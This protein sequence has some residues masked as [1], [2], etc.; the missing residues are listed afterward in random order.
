MKSE[1]DFDKKE[2]RYENKFV[3]PCL[4]KKEV[5]AVIFSNSHLFSE[6]YYERQINNIYFDSLDMEGFFDNVLGNSDRIKIRIR[7]YGDFEKVVNPVLELK[8]KRG[9][10]GTKLSFPLKNFSFPLSLDDM[11]EVFL[12]SNLPE[13]L[14]D[15]LKTQRF[16]LLNYYTRKYFLS[17]CK[18]FRITIDS[19]LTYGGVLTQN[20]LELS[21]KIKEEYNILELKYDSEKN[22]RDVSTQFPFRLTKSSKYVAGVTYFRGE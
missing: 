12:D 2:Y 7:W 16:A 3:V 11:Q 1:L 5:E 19:D 6:I 22:A 18:S 21:K 17:A 13:W 10:V 8:I 9:A 20:S 4:D 14:I 15:K